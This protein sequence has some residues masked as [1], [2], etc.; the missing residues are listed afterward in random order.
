MCGLD[1][2]LSLETYTQSRARDAFSY[3][4]EFYTSD[5]ALLLVSATLTP[6]AMAK[7]K[8]AK[9]TAKKAAKKKTAKRK[10]K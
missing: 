1:L 5:V 4:I 8:A 3:R 6:T 2:M 9:K 10:R 7:K